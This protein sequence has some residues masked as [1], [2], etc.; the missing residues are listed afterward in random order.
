MPTVLSK[1][2]G[3]LAFLVLVGCS[4]T[5]PS[6]DSG[7]P[8]V[9]SGNG[10]AGPADAAVEAAPDAKDGVTLAAM[11][12]GYTQSAYLSTAPERSFPSGATQVL[13]SAKDYIAIVD[14]DVGS[15]VLDLYETETPVTVNSF[16]FLA[17]HHFYEQVAFHR[18]I[19]D[20]MAQT[21]DPNTVAGKTSSWG[22]GGPGYAFKLEV[23]PSLNFDAP[24]VLGMARSSSPDSNGSQFFITFDA[25]PSLSQ[26]YTVW[27]KVTTG[28]DVL[29]KITLGE[30]PPTPTRMTEVRIGAKAK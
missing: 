24:G 26:N 22:K 15:I 12:A 30:P 8:S 5:A 2:G 19:T 18:V 13:D 7:A 27:G 14:T 23:N 20:F 4:A 25:Y 6:A 29:A 3:S 16:V 28:L 17:L 11:P 10:E 9:D 1:L 21:G